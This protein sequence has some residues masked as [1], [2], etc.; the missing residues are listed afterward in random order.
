MQSLHAACLDTQPICP[1]SESIMDGTRLRNILAL[2]LGTTGL[3]T[4]LSLVW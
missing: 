2:A 4:L 3:L 1:L